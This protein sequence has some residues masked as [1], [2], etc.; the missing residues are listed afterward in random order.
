MTHNKTF[1][2]RK[3]KCL[4]PAETERAACNSNSTSSRDGTIEAAAPAI[5][6][7]RMMGNKNALKPAST[8]TYDTHGRR[9]EQSRL[10]FKNLF[11]YPFCGIG[12]EKK[13]KKPIFLTFILIRFVRFVLI[14]FRPVSCR[15]LF[16]ADSKSELFIVLLYRS[17]SLRQRWEIIIMNWHRWATWARPDLIIFIRLRPYLARSARIQTAKPI[18]MNLPADWFLINKRFISRYQNRFIVFRICEHRERDRNAIAWLIHN[19]K[20]SNIRCCRLSSFFF[21]FVGLSY[22]LPG[23]WLTEWE[24]GFDACVKATHSTQPFRSLRSI[25]SFLTFPIVGLR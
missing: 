7:R 15:F 20:Y 24:Q 14:S 4:K 13:S 10:T 5:N 11:F 8:A 16:S 21:F 1:D 2:W 23:P 19:I 9:R 3:K 12:P 6:V 18:F 22:A 17:L 25:H